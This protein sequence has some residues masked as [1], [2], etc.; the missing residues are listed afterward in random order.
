MFLISTVYDENMYIG[1]GA[2]EDLSDF[3]K[4]KNIFQH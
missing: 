3:N 2:Y 1:T 4:H